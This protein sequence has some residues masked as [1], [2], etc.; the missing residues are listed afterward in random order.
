MNPGSAL[1]N[2]ITDEIFEDLRYSEST[3]VQ[4]IAI[5]GSTTVKGI[6]GSALDS[7]MGSLVWNDYAAVTLGNHYYT[8]YIVSYFPIVLDTGLPLIGEITV[9]QVGLVIKANVNVDTLTVSSY[10]VYDVFL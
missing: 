7:M 9:A 1:A 8:T 6:L 4:W 3:I 10:D 5:V 2:T